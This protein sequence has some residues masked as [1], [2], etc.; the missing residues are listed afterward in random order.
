VTTDPDSARAF[1]R[2]H[3]RLVYKSLS[4]IRSIVAILEP[5]DEARLDGVRTGPVQLQKWIDGLDVRVHIVGERVFAC[6]VRSTAA[7]YRYAGT[8]AELSPY[9]LPPAVGERAVALAHGMGLR[10]AGVDLRL[11]PDGS[12]VCFEVNPSPGFPWYEDS[13]GQPIAT[14]IAEELASGSVQD[15]RSKRP[16]RQSR[17]GGPSRARH[18]RPGPRE[19]VARSAT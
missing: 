19:G 5:G 10:L 12:W 4:G 1:L 8:A 18:S 16:P 6:A 13:T 3:R 17:A 14:A 2:S 9:D 15:A 11:T 7:D